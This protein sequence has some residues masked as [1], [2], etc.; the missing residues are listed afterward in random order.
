MVWRGADEG[1]S[2]RRVHAIIEGERLGR[3]Q[4]L[5][6]INADRHVIGFARRR[7]KHR[8]GGQWPESLDALCAQPV[9]GGADN[10]VIL[11]AKRTAFTRMRVHPL[12]ARRG[13]AMP[14]RLVRSRAVIR[15]VSTRSIFRQRLGDRIQRNVD[16][17]RHGA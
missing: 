14:N 11:L 6:V 4:C 10:C 7:M 12:T 3:N 2:Q 17:D 9:D 1:K 8:V 13:R 15:A 5:I 16:R